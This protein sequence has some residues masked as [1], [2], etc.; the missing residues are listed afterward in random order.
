MESINEK[1]LAQIVSLKP[2]AAVVFEKYDL[3]FCCKG[4]RTLQQACKED[5][6]KLRAV[7]HEL[8]KIFRHNLL[9]PGDTHFDKMDSSSL[10]DYIM[11]KHH[12]YVKESMPIIHS[13]LQKVVFK[14]GDS[15][16][17][18]HS[19]FKHFCDVK[20]ELE[21]HMYK[22]EN[23]LF[24]R[25][26]EIHDALEKSKMHWMPDKYYLSAPIQVMEEEHDNAG[27]SLHEIRKLT[28]NYNPP[29]NACTTYRLSFNELKEFEL[30][31]HQHVHLEN[32]ILFPRA[33]E[34]QE[35]LRQVLFN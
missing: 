28:Q 26:K 21:Q 32:N 30:D 23:I 22:E 13:H 2:S 8:D 3:D 19:I 5:Q 25:I 24:P 29:D 17:E 16:P 10:V 31:L 34:M 15:H 9:L 11:G 1:T 7:E 12:Q 20:E 18:L 35:K 27:N 14:H 4:K 33:Q 6:I